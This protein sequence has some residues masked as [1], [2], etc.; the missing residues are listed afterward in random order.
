[1][2]K[3]PLAAEYRRAQIGRR[4]RSRNAADYASR[5]FLTSDTPAGERDKPLIG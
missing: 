5:K 2:R 4:E 1:L 3:R